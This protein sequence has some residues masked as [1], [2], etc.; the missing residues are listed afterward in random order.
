MMAY[1]EFLADRMAQTLRELG[2]YYTEKRM[3]GGLVFMVDDKMC[4]GLNKEEM[5]VRINPD[6]VEE[7]LKKHGAK[8]MEFTNKPMKGFLTILPEG[9]DMDDDLTH[10]I[11]LA[12]DFNPLA[13]ASKKKK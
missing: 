13:K 3:F 5:M 6:E 1:N 9:Y 2:V 11:Q 12:V 10:W 8:T 4:V 7:A